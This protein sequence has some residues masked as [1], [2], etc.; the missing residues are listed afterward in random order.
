MAAF[1]LSTLL[2]VLSRGR[3]VQCL[4]DDVHVSLEEPYM[5]HFTYNHVGDGTVPMV[6]LSRLKVSS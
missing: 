5:E 4:A 6:S 1:P 3:L 2:M